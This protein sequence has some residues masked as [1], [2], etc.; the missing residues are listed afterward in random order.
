MFLPPVEEVIVT[1]I[2]SSNLLHPILAALSKMWQCDN[3]TIY[4]SP[5]QERAALV[6]VSSSGVFAARVRVDRP[7]MYKP[8]DEMRLRT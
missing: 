1:R 3:G 8:N 4:V 5:E 6:A 7:A 2:H